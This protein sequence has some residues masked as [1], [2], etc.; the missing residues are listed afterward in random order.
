MSP[1]SAYSIELKPDEWNENLPFQVHCY[2]NG[3]SHIW[4][5]N[6]CWLNRTTN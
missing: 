6:E 3:Y 2:S 1:C 5:T 4:W